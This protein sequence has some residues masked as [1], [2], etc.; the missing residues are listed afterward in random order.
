MLHGIR[1]GVL[2]YD[3]NERIVLANDFARQLLDLPPDFVGRPLRRSS[4]RADSPTW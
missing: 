4:R 1:E 3:K 2:G